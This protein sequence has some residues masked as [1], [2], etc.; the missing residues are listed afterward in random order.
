MD[1]AHLIMGNGKEPADSGAGRLRMSGLSV[2]GERVAVF[3]YSSLTT[4]GSDD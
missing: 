4:M 2:Y 3:Q 1:S